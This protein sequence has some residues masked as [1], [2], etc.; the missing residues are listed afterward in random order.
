MITFTLWKSKHQ[1]KG[2]ECSGHA[3]FAEEGSDIVCSAVSA[4]VINTVNSIDHFTKDDY[5]VEQAEDGGFLR[6]KF[7]G[8]LSE[9][10][11]L[12]MDS[13]I[14]GLENIAADYEDYITLLL[15]EV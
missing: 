10:S 6:V 12:L 15:E 7:T 13:L 2:F 8:E 1:Y 4:L 11:G 3:D 9:Q 5:E 14:L